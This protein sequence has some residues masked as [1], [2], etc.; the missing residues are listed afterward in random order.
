M[1]F[2]S[3]VK[4]IAGP[5]IGGVGSIV[6]GLLGDESQK[7][8]TNMNIAMQREFAQN[9]IR[10]K[11]ADAKAAGLH[12]LA[13]LGASTASFSPIAV[14]DPIG[15]AL[16]AAG[17]DLSR[18]F[19]AKQTQGER[20]SE[21]LLLAQIE[22]QEIENAFKASQ[23]ARLSSPTQ[24]PPPMQGSIEVQPS[25]IT[26]TRVGNPSLEAAPP[27]PAVKEFINADGTVTTW[28]SAE[29]K[30]AIEDSLY[31]YEHMWRNRISPFLKRTFS[32]RFTGLSDWKPARRY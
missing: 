14:G 9:G 17:Q 29:A 21:R 2:G 11:V 1:G 13:A 20:L 24:M 4:S 6:G 5:L 22:G 23:M 7:D 32:G 12:P 31:E 8:A 28:P 30:Q 16:A 25:K 10:W 26:S 27:A 19:M 18:A 3:F 15:S